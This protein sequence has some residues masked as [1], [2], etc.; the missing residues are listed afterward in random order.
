[1]PAVSIAIA[2][3]RL[4]S[5]A[6]PAILLAAGLLESALAGPNDPP[7]PGD[8]NRRRGAKT[9]G[10]LRQMDANHDGVIDASEVRPEQKPILD[11]LTQR[12]GMQVQFPLSLARVRE[13]MDAYYARPGNS[14]P[15]SPGSGPGFRPPGPGS[16]M[17]PGGFGAPSG[18]SVAGFGSSNTSTPSMAS[19]SAPSSSAGMWNSSSSATPTAATQVEDRL[20]VYA[21]GLMKRYDK[22]NS[23]MLERDEWSQMRGDWKSADTNGDDRISLDE[24]V[25]RFAAYRARYASRSSVSPVSSSSSYSP[26]SGAAGSG[27]YVASSVGSRPLTPDA[28]KPYRFL[29]PAERLPAGLP[30]WF[31]RRDLNGDGQVTLAEFAETLTDD[32]AAEFA[33]YDMNNDGVITPQEYLAAQRQPR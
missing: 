12:Y 24:I 18:G 15:H 23:G 1:V 2:L 28:R 16:P 32:L 11:R 22:N 5:R 33:R 3:C 19:P 14:G 26:S 20:R 6:V 8:P 30:E 13:A 9:E 21:S 7:P 25:G 31:A 29:T 10:Y 27:T 4:L 17:G